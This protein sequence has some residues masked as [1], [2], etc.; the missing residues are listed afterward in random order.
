MNKA[1]YH[2]VVSRGAPDFPVEYH[3]VDE[4]HP[5]YRML[6][7]WHND[8]ELERV[9]S[10]QMTLTLN[11]QTF[12]MSPGD[13]VLIPGGVIH[14]AE[15]QNCVYECIVFPR[16][17]LDIT[18]RTRDISIAQL[19][20]PVFFSCDGVV[21]RVFDS[22]K[23]DEKANAFRVLADL[24]DIIH[25]AAMAQD[26]ALAVASEYKM[27][28]IKVAIRYIEDHLHRAITLEE[29][30]RVCSTS[31]NYFCSF[32]KEITGKTPG[33]YITALRIETASKLL[34]AGNTVADTAFACGFH[35][36]SYFISVFRKR[37]GVSP[38]QYI[39]R[40]EQSL[41]E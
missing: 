37:V 36:V 5:S 22:M 29:L 20:K 6:L 12:R 10:G 11:N 14:G 27:E 19:Q 17:F 18:R 35:D 40:F 13:S 7:Q 15:P 39:K 38:K 9:V 1:I 3:Y 16:S 8:V 25:R 24:Y 34:L 41:S 4:S 32:F 26:N 21:A 31:P 33:E 23:T 2:E 30:S 28:R